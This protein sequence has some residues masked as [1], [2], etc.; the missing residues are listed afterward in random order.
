MGPH[1][2]EPDPVLHQSTRLQI[3]TYLYVNRQ[4]PLSQ[5]RGD[6]RLTPGNSA[7][8]LTRLTKEG[9]VETRRILAGL[10]EVHVFITEAGAEALEAYVARLNAFMAPVR[11]RG[12]S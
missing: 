7:T 9:Y 5:M 10:F 11:G 3:M 2:F 8:H 1:A 12:D 4:A 6:L